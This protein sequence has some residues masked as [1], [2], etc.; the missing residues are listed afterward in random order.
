[1]EEVL[2]SVLVGCLV[3]KKRE[4]SRKPRSK[5]SRKWLLMRREFSHVK[6]MQELSNEPN[7]WRNYLKMDE[8]TYHELLSLVSPFITKHDTLM[9]KAISPH[10]RLSATLRFLATGRTLKDI[11]YSTAISKPSLSSIIPE[12]CEAI[13]KVLQQFIQFPKTADDWLKIASDFEEKWQ[14]P[15][16][17]G[18][19]DGKHIR[20]VPPKDSGSYYFN[21]KKTHSI[22]LMA[23]ANAH[24]E[25]I[26]CDVGTNGRI[27]D[28]GVINNTLFYEKLINH[29]L[30][31]PGPEPVSFDLDL[32]Y[33]FVGDDAFALR[34]DLIKPYGRESLN[35]ERRICNYRISRARRVVENSFGILASRFRIFHTAINLN[36]KTIESLVLACCA[37]HNFLMKKSCN[38]SSPKSYDR[39]D[40]IDGTKQ[41]GARP[42]PDKFHN[43]DRSSGGQVLQQAKTVREK[44]C[45]Y[46]N[47]EGSVPWQEKFALK[48]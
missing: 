27:S 10:E 14:F 38:Y 25:F 41:L 36:V 15:H 13:Y 47:G 26:L 35:N 30:N 21:Y 17:L 46:F 24:C 37:L 29:Q 39:E 43:L 28:G 20:I 16:C 22:V 6:L 23:I 31:I 5:W 34:P 45:T 11:E 32:E 1:M 7:D 48:V 44:F 8:G 18:A 4:N 42:H 33:V 12:T 9:R 19:V 3:V 40:I 2:L